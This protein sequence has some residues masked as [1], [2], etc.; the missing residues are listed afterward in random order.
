MTDIEVLF[1]Q[2]TRE[3]DFDAPELLAY[4]ATDRLLLETIA[5][6][7]EL[8]QIAREPD[9]LVVIGDRHGALTLGART[10]LGAHRVRVH[11]D[12][13][14]AERALAQNAAR[15]GLADVSAYTNH[16]LDAA[17][18][19]DAR[20][21]MLQLPRSLA[22]L[23]EIA[24]AI[25]RWAS[26][27]VT[28]LAGGRVKHMT[29]AM[30]EVLRRS[31]GEVSAGLARQKSRVLVAR[32]PRPAAELG[33]P[34]FPV[35]GDDPDLTF[36]LAAYGATFGGAEFDHGSRLL[37]ATLTDAGWPEADRIVDLGCG[38][39]VLGVAAALARS[40]ARIIA[41]DQ[42]AA[43]IAATRLT[44]AAAGVADR[45]EVHRADATEAVPD[46]WAD[47][48]LLNPPFHTGAAVHAGV[49]RRLIR[50]AARAL[51]PGGE[52]RIVFN[53]HL[54][55]RPFVDRAIGPTRQIA[56]N[57]T[58]TVLSAVRRPNV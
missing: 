15:L 37:L 7:D 3:P 38:N 49:A 31:F 52:L 26:P 57:R 13:L 54:G 29:R 17:L 58:F 34:P 50:S 42:S 6:D 30:N 36:R 9:R 48:V 12:P 32:A 10:V 8:A 56:K 21:V 4:D 39:G 55:Y 47:L 24:H 51:H 23:D 20:L 28:V 5:D 46:A 53:S 35:W 1:A 25:A 44:A 40:T 18:L 14:L 27:E 33:D 45:V 22:E 19:S 43:A 41:S 16:P 11:Q 2:L